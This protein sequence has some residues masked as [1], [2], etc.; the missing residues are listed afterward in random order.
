MFLPIGDFPNPPRAQWVT[1]ILVAV[2]VAIFLFISLPLESRPFDPAATRSERRATELEEM[3]KV[4]K[5]YFRGDRQVFEASLTDNSFFTYR[6]GYKPGK[7]GLLSLFVCMFLHGGFWHILFNMWFLWIFGDNIEYRL[8][9][10]PFLG[11]YLG[12]GIVA[13]LGFSLLNSGSMVPLVGASGA[14]AGVMGMYL[15]LCRHNYV[16][17]LIFFFLI[18][19]VHMRAFWWL[20]IYMVL[21]NVWP[22]LQ[23]AETNTALEAHLGGFAAGA[24]LALIIR[25]FKGP[26]PA[27]WESRG[28]APKRPEFR[29]IEPPHEVFAK[30][31]RDGHM[32][33]AANAFPALAAEK[34]TP[35]DP[36]DVFTLA[37]WLYEN[38]FAA[39]SAAVFRYYLRSFPTGDDLD[40]VH[41]GLG[42]LMARRMGNPV[43][44]REHLL[45]AID[46]AEGDP[47]VVATARAELDRIG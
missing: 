33:E 21:T 13:T 7:P 9:A 28:P 38:G 44:A 22:Y 27:P 41:L 20:I 25:H 1:R 46:L 36:S 26:G 32:E 39:E 11:A 30:A 2:N 24:A 31:I 14:I 6:Y 5:A 10:I 35:A 43:G 23:G 4:Q 45:T 12:T 37:Q 40:R 47:A 18:T 15:I 16:R 17:V 34:G 42:I 29:V 8:G 19:I 3:W